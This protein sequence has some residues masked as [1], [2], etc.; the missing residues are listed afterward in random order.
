M[1]T[2]KCLQRKIGMLLLI[3][4]VLLG[5]CS[6]TTS[7]TKST[8][9]TNTTEEKQFKSDKEANVNAKQQSTN[10]S[11]KKNQ[12]VSLPKGLIT[13]TIIRNVDGDTVHV[14][15]KGKD[16]DI[17][18]LLIDTPETHKPGTPVQPYGP[19]ASAYA[20]QELAVGTKVKLE[21]GVKGHERDKYGRLLAYIYLPNGKMYNE[22]VVKKGLARV[23]YIYEP[24]T[25]HLKELKNDESY[26][27]KHKLGIWSIPGYVTDRGYNMDAKGAAHTVSSSPN[28]STQNSSNQSFKNNP[29]D[30]KESNT[31]CKGKIKGNANSK[32]YHVPGG[33]FYDRTRDNIVWFC[34]E[35]DAIKAGYRKSQR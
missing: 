8:N 22:E 14:S 7:T 25:K 16:E 34:T 30:D 18:L 13:A 29:A 3:I 33:A 12:I 35:S 9:T 28:T 26:A 4:S 23:A 21:E 17:R 1:A 6:Q 19:E 20:E 10:Q 24:N 11:N 27:R 5:A 2:K 31:S 32:I 15:I